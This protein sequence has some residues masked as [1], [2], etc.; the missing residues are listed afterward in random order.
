MPDAPRLFGRLR[1][2]ASAL[3]ASHPEA[4]HA[5]RETTTALLTVAVIGATLF[6][7]SG[8]WPPLV[9]VESPSM[10]P[11]IYR[12][13]LIFVTEEHRSA[14]AAARGE[15][16]VVTARAGET[17]GYRSFGGRGD[18]IVYRPDGSAAATPII[19]RAVFW[20]DAGENWYDRADPAVMAGEG[21]DCGDAPNCP[22]PH[23][24]FVTK[25]DSNA[26]YDQAEGLS[27]PVR[28]AWVVGTAE[29]RVPWL[30][31]IR[32]RMEALSAAFGSATVFGPS[33]A[34]AGGP[35][36]AP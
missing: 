6:A 14:P 24:G 22:A 9:A 11:N 5:V 12:T 29:L 21:T 30:G 27:A 33:S 17:S 15:T 26:F 16:G 20:V 31:W 10:E 32:L 25:G 28:P 8:L 7:A 4:A 35:T 13:D 18:V 36:A 19:H 2:R 34:T 23:A 1:E 3:A